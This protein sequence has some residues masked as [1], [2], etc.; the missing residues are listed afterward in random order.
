[1]LLFCDGGQFFDSFSHD[2]PIIKDFLMLPG[3]WTERGGWR[4]VKK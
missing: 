3:L 2:Y 1:M 4:G